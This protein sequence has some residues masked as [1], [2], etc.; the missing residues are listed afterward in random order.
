MLDALR[1]SGV[2]EAV[3]KMVMDQCA[4]HRQQET[5]KAKGQNS[6][7]DNS[8]KSGNTQ[9]AVKTTDK[10]QNDYNNAMAV[11]VELGACDSAV[12]RDFMLRLICVGA[13]EQDREAVH[14]NGVVLV[15][16]KLEGYPSRG[17]AQAVCVEQ[18]EG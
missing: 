11:G 18:R 2:D 5:Q 15:G 7:K 12:D 10:P 16:G 13:G 14:R 1:A 4:A 6:R 8:E 3:L 9:P 17:R